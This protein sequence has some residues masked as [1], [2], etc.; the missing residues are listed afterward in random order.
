MISLGEAE[1]HL[2]GLG[3]RLGLGEIVGGSLGVGVVGRGLHQISAL[4]SGVRAAAGEH[5]E[6]QSGIDDGAHLAVHMREECR[7][8]RGATYE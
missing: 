5:C 7:S 8:A 6:D 3:A 4:R 1:T 2:F